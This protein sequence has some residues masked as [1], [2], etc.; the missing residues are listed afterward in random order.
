MMIRPYIDRL[1]S[2]GFTVEW[3]ETDRTLAYRT[4]DTGS[5]VKLGLTDDDETNHEFVEKFVSHAEK[6]YPLICQ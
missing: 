3:N 4:P 6:N 2:M 1:Q 5:R